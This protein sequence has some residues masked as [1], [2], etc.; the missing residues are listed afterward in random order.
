V[1]MIFRLPGRIPEGQTVDVHMNSVDMMP[2][3]LDFVG[4]PVPAG[5]AGRSVRP[6]I[7]GKPNDYAPA[8]CERTGLNYN[9][10]QR[11]IRN[12]GW[13]YVFNSAWESELFHLSTDPGEVTNLYT[14]PDYRNVRNDLHRQLRDW[15]V[16]TGDKG[17]EKMPEA[18]PEEA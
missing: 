14:D 10:V 15:M 16:R 18:P 9:W 4:M 6:F 8:F 2:T 13:K 12:S 5:I 17:V 3:L 1:P 7:E 11:M